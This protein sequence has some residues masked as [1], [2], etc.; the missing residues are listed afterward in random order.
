MGFAGQY[1]VVV[2]ELSEPAQR[3]LRLGYG[4]LGRNSRGDVGIPLREY[5]VRTV[6]AIVDNL[7]ACNRRW[8]N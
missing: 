8:S 1:R 6:V 2:V 4:L 7:V 5:R 3:E